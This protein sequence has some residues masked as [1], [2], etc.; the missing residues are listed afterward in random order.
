MQTHSSP[1]NAF[2]AQRGFHAG[3]ACRKM[4]TGFTS[5]MKLLRA[6]LPRRIGLG[7]SVLG[8][9]LYGSAWADIALQDGSLAVTTSTGSTSVS[10]NNFTVT[11]GASVLVVSLVDRN[12][13]TANS[14]PATLDWTGGGLPQTVWQV[15]SVNGAGSTW[16]WANIYYLF[17]PAPGTATITAT[18]TSGGT[19]SVMAIQAYTL[20]GVDT[21]V[22]PVPYATNGNPVGS[23]TL[24]LGSDTPIHGWA[25]V[26]SHYGTTSGNG[27][28]LSATDGTPNFT[29][30]SVTIQEAMGY[31]SDLISTASTITG[32]DTS[33]GTQKLALGAA[34]FAPAWPGP[35]A[36]AGLT[37]TDGQTN[38][39]DLS[40]TDISG[41]TATGF[42][43]WRAPSGGS[44]TSIATLGAVTSYTD[45]TAS[46]WTTW[47]YNVQAVG[48]SGAGPFSGIASATPVGTPLAPTGVTVV[49]I[50][51]SAVLNWTAPAG[52][53]RYNVLRSTTSGSGY[54]SVAT[55][56]T[57]TSYTNTGLTPN[58]SYYYVVQAVND[59]G[60]SPD[61]AE[62]AVTPLSAP[63]TFVATGATNKV[64]LSWADTTGGKAS[65]YLVL[66]SIIS[67]GG[68]DGYQTIAI[69]DGNASTTFTDKTVYTGYTYYYI[70]QAT[71]ANATS[72]ASAQAS[73]SPIWYM[74][75]I[76]VPIAILDPISTGSFSSGSRTVTM[77]FSVS[78]GASALVFTLYDANNN[79]S[80]SFRGP[81]M[82]WSNI[83]L[84]VTQPFTVAATAN[85]MGY[86]YSWGSV[87]Y[88]MNPQP[89]VGVLIGT[90]PTG[91]HNGMFSQAY[92][93]VGV[94]PNTIPE[95][96]GIGNSSAKTLSVTTSP[97]TVLNSWAQAIAVNYNGGGGNDVTISSSSG[98]IAQNNYRF[99]GSQTTFGY[100]TNINPGSGTITATGTGSPTLMYLAEATFA[101]LVTLSPP[102]GVTATGQ[103][104]QIALSWS[105]VSG[106]TSYEVLRSTTS[107]SGYTVIRTNVG[108][109]STTFTDT[110]VVNYTTYFYVVQAANASGVSL[111]STEVSAHAVGLPGELAVTAFGNVNQ[112][113]LS[114][115]A[116]TDATSYH[117]YRS[118]TSS[119]GY[120][121]IGSP[122]SP[123]FIDTAVVNG[124]R[125][126]YEVNV[127]NSFGTGPNS[128]PVNA[129]PCVA[130]LTNWIGD[131]RSDA[132]VA[133]WGTLSGAPTILYYAGDIP[134]GPSEGSLEMDATFGPGT[135]GELNG[136]AK[137]VSPNFNVSTY[138][139][140]ELDMYNYGGTWDQYGAISAVQLNLQVPV[141]GTPTYVRGTFGDIQLTRDGG[142]GVWGHYVAPLADWNAYDLTQVSA[143][144]INVLDFN[145]VAGATPVAMH[146][147]NIAFCGAPAWTPV[148]SVTSRTIASGSGGVTLTGTVSSMVGGAPVYLWIGT[149]ITVTINNLTQPTAISDSTGGFA[150]D[151]NT[152][153]FADGTYPVKY[154]AAG[155]MVALV[156][157][158]NTSTTLT[159]TVN[160]PPT[161][162]KILP[163]SVDA[164]GA[165]L[166]LSVATESG[167]DYYLLS[168]TNLV[169][170]AVWVTNKITAGTGGT[171]TNLVP[172][173]KSQKALFLKY[174][175]E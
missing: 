90:E 110:S 135:T 134:N 51:N 31:V 93:L 131:F 81:D 109:A 9:F 92:T 118:L 120:S 165:N 41:G 17:N 18:D 169:P 98:G 87:W 143:F 154:A 48:G 171:I 132:D 61:S 4:T 96:L 150:I 94:D 3:L 45:S 142:G 88:L 21:A 38:K 156:G 34:V 113:D 25:A 15:V 145:Y 163:P 11:P 63:N 136:I 67:G 175:V 80:G 164:T 77:P 73:A 125:Y 43:V 158:T 74:P 30:T 82:V 52:T 151:F 147:A 99:S 140:I 100:I 50:G 105:S 129:I 27:F 174:L 124:T 97:N 102:A 54:S 103:N 85:S 101:P 68:A 71:S 122:T 37:A 1:R 60:T 106:A 78:A 44:W 14:G 108:N 16:A 2:L 139:T 5:P 172:I 19:P 161:E 12:N 162:P 121:L 168:T 8:L 123:G 127:E 86:N 56:V 6:S 10:A 167:H 76:A 133:S 173:N 40:W 153:G 152:A 55:G 79:D 49:G 42:I 22:L 46:A 157:A 70:I 130:F 39:V 115:A 138:K 116:Q 59:L 7:L 128:S 57:S 84:G 119:G 75:A 13:S 33:G 112:V 58:T 160:V 137:L 20:S 28:Q 146:Y 155:D 144:G 62:V 89:G 149:P 65:G 36:P 72:A 170:P 26:C 35:A 83:T 141:N 66:R 91:A 114:W 117:V 64:N 53:I 24:L 95:G 159:L 23:R 47:N 107:G 32:R 29:R 104:N 166:V 111:Y 126:Y 148:F 69:L